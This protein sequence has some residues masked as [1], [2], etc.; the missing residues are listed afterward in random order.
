MINVV[1]V[2]Q[3]INSKIY[4]PEWVYK[5]ERSIARNLK[6]PYNFICLSDVPLTCNY[7]LM[8]SNNDGWW[9]KL[10]L[11]NK[12]LL[13]IDNS[14]YF[15]LDIVIIKSLTEIVNLICNSVDEFCMC[16]EPT[17][18][19]NSSIMYWKKTPTQLYDMYIENPQKWHKQFKSVPLLGDQAFISTHTTVIPIENY[20]PQNY[21][22]WTSPTSLNTADDTGIIIFT[23]IKSKPSK[24]E[25]ASLD[26]ITS[27]W[28]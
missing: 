20:M 22:A 12:N 27:N 21:I 24:K 5:L 2:L 15:D 14:I 26:I 19:L 11:F 25:F 17:G 6:I 28:Y 13:T 9:N 4:T 1:C 8:E 16:T 18:I 3:S 23:S 7:V 10:Q